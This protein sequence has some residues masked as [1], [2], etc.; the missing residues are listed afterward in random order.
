M[1]SCMFRRASTVNRHSYSY[2]VHIHHLSI[3]LNQPI[4]PAAPHQSVEIPSTG[5]YAP[6]KEESEFFFG[7]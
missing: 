1:L 6:E 4:N 3:F 5:T 2:Q 7:S